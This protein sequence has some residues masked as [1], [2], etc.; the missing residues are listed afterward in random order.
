MTRSLIAADLL[1][2]IHF[3]REVIMQYKKNITISS[4]EFIK[5]F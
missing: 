5:S 3:K 1:N 4:Q 2:F